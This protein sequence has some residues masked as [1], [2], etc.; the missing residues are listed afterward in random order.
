MKNCTYSIFFTLTFTLLL[1][2]I[3]G[4]AGDGSNLRPANAADPVTTASQPTAPL[5][6]KAT[7]ASTLPANIAP[8]PSVA[9]IES[10]EELRDQAAGYF[11]ANNQAQALAIMTQAIKQF[12]NDPLNYLQRGTFYAV[13]QN[14]P[15]AIADLRRATELDPKSAD[16]WTNLG[17][18]LLRNGDFAAAQTPSAKA[19][20]LTP[21]YTAAFNL[22]LTYFLQ[23]DNSTARSWYHKS[24]LL[25]PSEEALRT[26][27]LDAFNWFIAHNWHKDASRAEEA[28]NEREAK[29]VLAQSQNAE[30]AKIEL[31]QQRLATQQ[32]NFLKESQSTVATLNLQLSNIQG[33][34]R[35]LGRNNPN[36][37]R[38]YQLLAGIF[39]NLATGYTLKRDYI[40]AAPLFQQ[41][42][43]ISS[44]ALGDDYM[45]V[46]DILYRMASAYN[47]QQ[48]YSD[49]AKL[50]ERALAIKEKHLG[51]YHD[52]LTLTLTSLAT[53]YREQDR[54]NDAERLLKRLLTITE[55]SKDIT[56]QHTA[57]LQLALIYQKQGR[58]LDA[59]VVQL[60]AHNLAKQPQATDATSAMVTAQSFTAPV[61]TNQSPPPTPAPATN[62]P[63][64][65]PD[66]NHNQTSSTAAED[67]Q[68]LEQAAHTLLSNGLELLETNNPAA[69]DKILQRYLNIRSAVFGSNHPV[70]VEDIST[71]ADSYKEKILYS[72]A[73]PWYQ[74][75]LTLSAQVLG[76]NHPDHIKLLRKIASF[77]NMAGDY[78]KA[79]RLYQQVLALRQQAGVNTL[80]VAESFDDL[81]SFYANQ[82]RYSEAELLCRQALTIRETLL[83][84]DHADI[85]G[86]LVSLARIYRD[87]GRYTEAEPLY[88]RAQQIGQHLVAMFPQIGIAPGTQYASLRL[89]A[90][91]KRTG[92][93]DIALANVGLAS[94]YQQQQRY[95][96]AEK[97]IKDAQDIYQQ[98]Y[99]PN[100]FI[101]F[102]LLGQLATLYVEQKRYP[103]AEPLA[104]TSLAGVQQTFGEHHPYILGQLTLLAKIYR[105][106]GRY[107]EA[108]TLY[109]QALTITTE[110]YGAQHIN[111]VRILQGLANVYQKQ[112][113][114][115]LA[116]EHIRHASDILHQYQTTAI[117][118]RLTFMDDRHVT[119]KDLFLLHLGILAN[120]QQTTPTDDDITESFEIGQFNHG[121]DVGT[122]LAEM[123][124]RTAKGNG[125]LAN[126]T[127]QQQDALHAYQ[128]TDKT[129]VELLSQPPDKR[130]IVAEQNLRTR[131]TELKTTLVA[132]NAQLSSQFPDYMN[133]VNSQAITVSQVQQLL[134]SGEGLVAYTLGEDKSFVWL[135]TTQ[136]ASFRQINRNQAEI[137]QQVQALRATLDPDANFQLAQPFPVTTA[138]ALYQDL[139]GPEAA[140]LAIVKTLFVVA[141]GA[142][143]GLP[144][145][146][147]VTVPSTGDPKDYQHVAWLSRQLATVTLPTVSSLRALRTLASKGASAGQPFVG[148]GDPDFQ[149]SINNHQR[150]VAGV[151]LTRP[152]STGLAD[153]DTLRKILP[154]LPET[155]AELRAIANTLGAGSDSIFLRSQATVSMVDATPLVNY[156]VVDF[157]THALVTGEMKEYQLGQAE[158]AIA[159]TPPQVATPDNDG[160]LRASQ[161]AQLKL[162]ADWVVLSACNTAAPDGTPGAVGL[163][164][165]AKAFF[166]A[167]AR[168]ML[169]SHWS[170]VSAPAVA[171]TTGMFKQWQ[172]HPEIGRAEALRRAEM[173]VLDHPERPYFTHPGA[174]APFVVAGEG[175]VGR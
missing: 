171:L 154:P 147:L 101:R 22:G 156:R 98:L 125:A 52:D 110:I 168:A 16:A 122:A 74:R 25:L 87:A 12:P 162:N 77:Y 21:N 7:V 48:R 30:Q 39:K 165:L 163:S 32:A 60:R 135:I 27:P 94:V 41:A 167:G 33:L 75:A 138:Y 58:Y 67:M 66:I 149:G 97:S 134:K 150:G 112:G 166:Y 169:V 142:L 116:L 69:A 31:A 157:A 145:S 175:G 64:V 100:H 143:E 4:C 53:C 139:L 65:V 35:S 34:E 131:L 78:S 70:I 174:W 36:V 73:E 103:D 59:D 99:G 56:Q 55:H 63:Q 44:H 18:C 121:N 62:L 57:L 132:L 2:L 72:Y 153:P 172:D 137:N 47:D 46:T 19:Y 130:N 29:A 141:D 91:T 15:P 80:A 6:V 148:F 155:A 111:T 40:A 20:A 24:M 104:K 10:A 3:P 45:E 93:S 9:T 71:I 76:A 105:E 26:G 79:A 86:N 114:M 124:T 128:K 8:V 95:T 160:L 89:G 84:P 13:T 83:Q 136:S 115:R 102:G 127:R 106:Q 146:V 140:Q 152:T 88:K 119:Y 129:L 14:F 81:C 92:L 37:V 61:L 38:G 96:E 126:L 1:A 50:F 108:E 51:L 85:A 133:L 109:K 161:V 117:N 23:G 144:F 164:G 151:R 43:A 118:D 28:G 68:V 159:L 49:A 107:P 113:Q 42:L 5:V 11:Y 173:M 123:A 170:V 90:L 17:G 82:G 120:N 158:P 54:F